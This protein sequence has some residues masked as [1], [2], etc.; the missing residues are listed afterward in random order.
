V[1]QLAVI[2]FFDKPWTST[3]Y[4]EMPKSLEESLLFPDFT[5]EKAASFKITRGDME[6]TLKKKDQDQWVVAGEREDKAD[7]EWVARL[8][9]A[10]G[11]AKKNDPVSSSPDKWHHYEV[12]D[13]KGFFLKVWDEEGNILVDVVIGRNMGPMRG[14]YTRLAGSDEVVLVM[15]N[16]RR[17]VNKGKDLKHWYR[18]WRRKIIHWDMKKKNILSFEIDGP[19]GRIFFE[20]HMEEG[21]EGEESWTMTHPLQG[22]VSLERM[23][24]IVGTA[25]SLKAQS[26]ADSDLK[27]EDVGLVPPHLKLTLRKKG[28]E[29]IVIRVN[30]EGK[31][32]KDKALRYV[33]ADHEPGLIF[34][35]PSN[36][37]YDYGVKPESFFK[38]EEAGDQ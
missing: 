24:K 20:H 9:D 13:E 3:D 31:S 15:V 6:I 33:M 23:N 27:P 18:A 19:R 35:V 14:T 10:V 28:G 26:F 11:Q 37:F 1:I 29:T 21:P 2:F 30:K 12:D 32:G 8:L 4:K 17:V 16:I 22:E 7:I 34:R 36:L 38:K 5:A 25:C